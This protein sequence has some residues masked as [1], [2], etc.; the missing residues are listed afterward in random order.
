MDVKPDMK[1]GI[2][3]SRKTWRTYSRGNRELE[4]SVEDHRLVL[5]TGAG[6]MRIPQKKFASAGEAGK[7]LEE[8]CR[9]LNI[10]KL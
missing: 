3:K 8:W 6:K 1:I 5:F 7:E 10:K 9:Q 2:L 4:S